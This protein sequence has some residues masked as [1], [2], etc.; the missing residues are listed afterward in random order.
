MDY[1]A[2]GTIVA[3]GQTQQVS[4][5]F[6]KRDLVIEISGEYPQTVSFQLT[7]DRCEKADMLN[8]GQTATIHFNL[9][10]RAW[11][12][13]EGQVKYFNTLECWKVTTQPSEGQV[14]ESQSDDLPY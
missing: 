9:R 14:A 11:T 8:T 7:Q 4:E 12:D 5:K 3:I 2:T 10:G 13:K 6:R 1:T